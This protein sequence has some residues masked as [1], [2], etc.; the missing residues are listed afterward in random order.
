MSLPA[1]DS[2]GVPLS[3]LNGLVLDPEAGEVHE[4]PLH[5]RG[6]VIVDIEGPA[7]ADARVVDA[8]GA[9]VSPG[10]IDAHF[11]AYGVSLDLLELEALPTSYVV[12]QA[13]RRL[14]N[15]LQ[16]GF[17]TVRDV[18]GGDLGLVRALAEGLIAG[19]RYL[20]TGRALSQTGGHGDAR[21]ADLNLCC[22][23]GHMSEV[24]DG[25]ENLRRAVRERLR[26]G[27]HAI[28]I[29]A[30]GGVVSPSD[31]L[32]RCQY[33]AD[34]MRA[35]V[36]EAT[37][38][39]SYV[40]AH[41]YP[42]EA[43]RH[44]V[45]S[46]VRTVEH[47]NFLDRDTAEAMAA[48]GI[49][50]VP[51]LIAYDSIARRGAALGLPPASSAKNDEVLAAGLDSLET[52]RRAGVSVGFGTDLMGDLEDEQLH[53]FR[54]R[55]DVHSV[56][57]VLRSATSVNAEIIRR[58]DL[59]SLAVAT[60]ADLVVFSGNPLETPDVLWSRPR[61]VVQGGAVVGGLAIR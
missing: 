29:F 36:D 52:A 18:A 42:P 6:G 44:A 4:H 5:V 35:V 32:R 51:T 7:P 53:E 27:A 49:Y 28:K 17:T 37:R 34:E 40:S 56:L 31:L 30:S 46:G 3:I 47:G 48:T 25:V 26:T 61:S 55:L 43:V 45:D 2:T 24:V 21:P 8:R 59:G 22:G 33:S 11:H 10:L 15:A 41:A 20:F 54:L 9:L 38:G 14:G 60:P 1:G 39:G 13:V 12:S 57:E 50:L 16:R 23:G 19:P 58:P